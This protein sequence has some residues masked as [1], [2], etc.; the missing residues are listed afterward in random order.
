MPTGRGGAYW[1]WTIRKMVDHINK[2]FL[3]GIK[4]YQGLPLRYRENRHVMH[5]YQAFRSVLFNGTKAY[6]IFYN[7]FK[8]SY[9]R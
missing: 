8:F 2:L 4:P 5:H 6:Q 7:L 1:Y 3:N 9:L